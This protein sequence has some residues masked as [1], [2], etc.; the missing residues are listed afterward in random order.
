MLSGLGCSG[1]RTQLVHRNVN[2]QSLSNAGTQA[3][4]DFVTVWVHGTS[5]NPLIRKW[6][7]S[8]L[9]ITHFEDLSD[10]YTLKSIGSALDAYDNK[11]FPKSVFYTFGWSGKLS[12]KARE[13]AGHDL[14][15]ALRTLSANYEKNYG[16]K[17]RLRVV[18][19]SH[20]CN[21]ALNAAD[22]LALG[23]D[24][25]V[26]EELVL[27]ACPVQYA[28]SSKLKSPAFRNIF[29][30][31]STADLTQVLDPQGLNRE[32]YES[33]GKLFSERRFPSQTNLVQAQIRWE[34]LGLWHIGF[35]RERFGKA[36]PAI[37]NE[38]RRRDANEPDYLIDISDT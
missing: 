1:I 17:P 22:K 27:L 14:D 6:H 26:V 10:D 18:T 23:K 38:L 24:S 34:G 12:F 11:H 32:G 13:L 35:V 28:T 25:M 2:L 36:L 29:G 19:H 3:T 31:Y 4:P 9:G 20:G 30:L 7:T 37:L 15:L 21:V 16:Q 5:Q 33:G 8:P